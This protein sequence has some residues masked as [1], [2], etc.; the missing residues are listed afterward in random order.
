M[1]YNYKTMTMFEVE[2]AIHD[3]RSAIYGELRE[4]RDVN[5]ELKEDAVIDEEQSVRW[6]REEVV[7]RNNSRNRKIANY[8]RKLNAVDKKVEDEIRRRIKEEYRFGDTVADIIFSAAYEDGHSNGYTEVYNYAQKYA[9]FAGRII[10][11]VVN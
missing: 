8:Q 10:D 1:D 3:E 11:A 5:P 9:E 4:F 2:V 7:R 6:N